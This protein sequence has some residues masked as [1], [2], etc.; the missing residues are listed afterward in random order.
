MKEK[1]IAVFVIIVII[2][3]CNMFMLG[4]KKIL[5]SMPL[6]GVEAL[7]GCEVSANPSE[8]TGYCTPILGGSGY[9]CITSGS[10]ETNCYVP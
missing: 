6:A 1:L 2:A 9:A 10:W 8:N 3:G 7:A 5:F 4:Q